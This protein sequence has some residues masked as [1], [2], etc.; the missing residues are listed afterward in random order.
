MLQNMSVNKYPT[1]TKIIPTH[2]ASTCT[3]PNMLKHPWSVVLF[4]V[5][6]GYEPVWKTLR[7]TKNR[8]KQYFQG[9]IVAVATEVIVRR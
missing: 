1:I 3:S 5:C 8:S 6:S 4:L 9:G 7:A 2:L